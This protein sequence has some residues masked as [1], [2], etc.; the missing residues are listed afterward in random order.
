MRRERSEVRAGFRVQVQRSEVRGQGSGFIVRVAVLAV[1]LLAGAMPPA[2]QV[3]DEDCVARPPG[4]VSTRGDYRRGASAFERAPARPW[5]MPTPWRWRRSIARNASGGRP[6]REGG[7]PSRK[8]WLTC[9]WRAA[10]ELLGWCAPTGRYDAPAA[11][12][13]LAELR[14]RPQRCAQA[15]LLHSEPVGAGRAATAAKALADGPKPMNATRAD[16]VAGSR[17][18]QAVAAVGGDPAA[19]AH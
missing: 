6:A 1:M 9:E 18:Q 3:T 5:M 19:A 11:L 13:R 7:R 16:V 12:A 10:L 14:D 8:P 17:G 15:A 4:A 2:P